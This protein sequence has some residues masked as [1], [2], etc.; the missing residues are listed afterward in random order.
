MTRRE[1]L[2]ILA[3]HREDLRARGVRSLALF[4]SVARGEASA[5]SDVD[6]PVEF[7]RPVGLF[8]FVRLRRASARGKGWQGVLLITVPVP[9]G[10]VPV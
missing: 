6:L 1:V 3:E 8:E 10:R 7:S 4:G 5:T 2:D 9:S